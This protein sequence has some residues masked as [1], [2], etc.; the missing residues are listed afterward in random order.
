[1]VVQAF[2]V[3]VGVEDVHGALFGA[4]E[5]GVDGV[6]AGDIG[7]KELRDAVG[8]LLLGAADVGEED[9]V[10]QVAAA[11]RVEIGPGAQVS[12]LSGAGLKY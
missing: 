4:V 7:P 8:D 3:A 1:M 11:E 10:S 6:F 5:D 9:A 2:G 12:T